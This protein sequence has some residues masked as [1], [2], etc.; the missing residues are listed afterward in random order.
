MLSD[1]ALARF[2]AAIRAAEPR[3]LEFWAVWGAYLR[4]CGE[5]TS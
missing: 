2:S 3:S 1:A 4:A 5:A